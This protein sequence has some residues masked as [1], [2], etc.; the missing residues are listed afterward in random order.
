[1]WDT[2]LADRL[3]GAGL[4]VVEVAGWQT[5]GSTT[6]NP[7]G[8][9]DHHTAGSA[10]GNA[11]SLTVCIY[12]R[13]GLPGPLCQVL[14]GRDNT[15][16]VI[17]AGRAN[18]AGTGGWQGLAG[19]S[20]VYGIERENVGTTAEPWRP[21]QT[22]AAARAHAALIRGRAGADMVCRHAEWTSR[23]VDTHS[24][25]GPTLRAMVDDYL[26]KG[27]SGPLPKD[28]FDMATREELE[29]VVR[30]FAP[31]PGV[32][33]GDP[34]GAV[35]IFGPGATRVWIDSWDTYLVSANYFKNLRL[36]NGTLFEPTAAEAAG[37][38]LVNRGEL[39]AHLGHEYTF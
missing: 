21:D 28:W 31:W 39:E 3:R 23:K 6:F 33:D 9:L 16:Y 1:M 2:G 24:V 35:F 29:D 12:G 26:T 18:H 27:G 34:S 7:Y 14:M 15:C 30:Q 13:T 20:S 5:R 25:H 19:N 37:Y 11:P 38:Y 8:A 10:S 22:D 17:A 32:V 36:N 4:N